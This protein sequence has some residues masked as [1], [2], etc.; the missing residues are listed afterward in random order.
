MTFKAVKGRTFVKMNRKKNNSTLYRYD[1]N[2]MKNNKKCSL[3]KLFNPLFNDIQKI[4]IC[5]INEI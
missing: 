4:N 5:I 1:H 3:N 2:Y